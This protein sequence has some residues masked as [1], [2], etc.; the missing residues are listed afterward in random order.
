MDIDVTARDL[1]YVPASSSILALNVQNVARAV[2]LAYT[3]QTLAQKLAYPGPHVKAAM[4]K[5][6]ARD[7]NNTYPSLVHLVHEL[8]STQHTATFGSAFVQPGFE[9]TLL[10]EIARVLAPYPLEQ[11]FGEALQY[12]ATLKNFQPPLASEQ[13]VRD[14]ADFLQSQQI[15]AHVL[16]LTADL[17]LMWRDAIQIPLATS[18]ADVP[19]ASSFAQQL[20]I[21]PRDYP[22]ANLPQFVTRFNFNYGQ[23]MDSIAD[24]LSTAREVNKYAINTPCLAMYYA[25]VADLYAPLQFPYDRGSAEHYNA[26]VRDFDAATQFVDQYGTFNATKDGTRD[27]IADLVSVGHTHDVTRAILYERIEGPNLLELQRYL[28]DN[29]QFDAV[30]A[31][32]L[33]WAFVP[34]VDVLHA[35]ATQRNLR[36]NTLSYTNV[37]ARNFTGD[38]SA[39]YYAVPTH[40]LGTLAAPYVMAIDSY[41]AVSAETRDHF[42]RHKLMPTSDPNY[43]KQLNVNKQVIE[44]FDELVVLHALTFVFEAWRGA[45]TYL[46]FP[47]HSF[48]ALEQYVRKELQQSKNWNKSYHGLILQYLFTLLMHHGFF[49]IIAVQPYDPLDTEAAGLTYPQFGIEATSSSAL[50]LHNEA[51]FSL[52]RSVATQ[53]ATTPVDSTTS[54]VNRGASVY[55]WVVSR[56]VF[57]VADPVLD[58]TLAQYPDV[59]A[60]TITCAF[61]DLTRASAAQL[62]H[63]SSLLPVELHTVDLITDWHTYHEAITR[64]VLPEN[65]ARMDTAWYEA[66]YTNSRNALQLAQQCIVP[67]YALQKLNAVIYALTRNANNLD[68]ALSLDE[69]PASAESAS[70][71][72][73][74][75]RD[76]ALRERVS[77]WVYSDTVDPLREFLLHFL[78][79]TVESRR[80]T[81][82]HLQRLVPS[83]AN[84]YATRTP[85]A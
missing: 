43:R 48:A 55:Q 25:N 47:E 75:A 57:N 29:V 74:I 46:S 16:Q 32:N 31:T 59:P 61:W 70:T 62:V 44:G 4:H 24:E 82:E 13:I 60:F 8:Q 51:L 72:S 54:A 45:S 41:G 35:M 6:L 66:L 76:R 56:A 21:V 73:S 78:L 23:H 81:L 2:N 30:V 22:L 68:A 64:H 28:I 14:I 3:P 58:T 15:A 83:P 77:H 85:N 18:A 38:S 11:W 5:T 7:A 49:T 19:S 37:R 36:H 1:A 71:T 17:A 52:P 40:F 79:K 67:L 53:D 65:A 39:S 69:L 50:T 34:L 20:D 33:I 26:I 12:Y 9:Q 27:R 80:R 10:N 84:V 63:P 42:Q